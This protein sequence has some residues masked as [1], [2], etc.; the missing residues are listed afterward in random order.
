MNFD[1]LSKGE[2]LKKLNQFIVNNEQ[3]ERLDSKMN[4]FN[5]FT[6]LKINQYEIRHSNMLAW[7]LDPS[8]NHNLGDMILK[9]MMAEVL[10]TEVKEERH[11]L[12]VT[13]V[14][15][16][17]FHDADVLRE[18]R[19]IDVLVVSK[20][21]KIVMLIENKIHAGLAEHQL[22]KYINSVYQ[23]YPGY[24]IIPVFL[25]L[26]GEEAPHSCYYSLSHSSICEIL[27]TSVRLYEDRLSRKVVDFI[28]YYI[29]T[30]EVL[31]MQDDQLIRLARDIYKQHSEAIDFIMQYGIA[32]TNS[33]GN[34]IDVMKERM[35]FLDESNT[36]GFTRTN[37]EYWFGPR[38]FTTANI[39][40]LTDTKWKSPYLFGC[41]FAKVGDKLKLILE[42][43]PMQDTQVRKKLLAYI[44]ANN[45]K[46]YFKLRDKQLQNDNG[47]YTKIRTCDI[48]ID[49]WDDTDG[50]VN[51]IKTLM[52]DVFQFDKVT[53]EIIR[54]YRQFQVENN[55]GDLV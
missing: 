21:N 41:F 30:L 14:L 45:D 55:L 49:D 31:T 16:G 19:N 24:S 36:E 11:T 53:A 6:I 29:K 9:K 42:V 40:K 47:K 26:T 34:A 33:F 38:E 15:M 12:T 48:L 10:I 32:S 18:W 28:Q 7:L 50:L 3:L 51:S 1:G 39:P 54:I 5:P 46:E 25:T 52:E 44:H 17:N 4:D 43:G 20:V 13:D 8:A 22:S 2:I 23:A 35:D 27:K 37:Q